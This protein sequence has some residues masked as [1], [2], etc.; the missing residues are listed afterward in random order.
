MTDETAVELYIDTG[1]KGEN[2][3]IFDALFNKRQEIAHAFGS[4]LSWERL[5]DK[6]GSR[7]RHIVK[8]GGLTDESKWQ[9][10]QDAMIVAMDK[11]SKALRP[12]FSRPNAY[13]AHA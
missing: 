9:A 1:D 3:S 4:E 12:Y 7:I 2:K 8:E 11:L 6:R 13:Q 10:M 5:D